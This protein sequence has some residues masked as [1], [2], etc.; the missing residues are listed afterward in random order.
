L[1]SLVPPHES[2]KATRLSGRFYRP[3]LDVLRF[4]AFLMVYLTHTIQVVP[5]SPHWVIALSNA[6]GFGVPIFFALSAYLITEL[7]MIEKRRSGTVDLPAFYVRRC[8]RIWPLYFLLLFLG[9]ALSRASSEEI[10]V[11]ALLAY[12]FFVGNWYTSFHDFL[13]HAIGPLW[14]IPVEEQFYLFWPIFVR[15]LGRRGLGVLCCAGWTLSQATLIALCR[16]NNI[17]EPKIWANS[18]VHLQYFALGAGVS[19]YL[20]GAIPR[21]NGGLRTVM[22]G[23]AFVILFVSDFALN[24]NTPGPQA[25]FAQGYLELLFGGL[26]TA[27]LLIGFLGCGGL[28]KRI[29]LRYLGKISY[30]LYLFHIPC[31]TLVRKLAP[32]LLGHASPLFSAVVA[33]P[34]TIGVASVSYR[35]FE[36]PFL[37]MKERF[38]VVQ[39][40][41][42]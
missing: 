4:V 7:L 36:S 35:Y 10:S 41:G 3:E 40:R 13:P 19:L 9:F 27:L 1:D 30:G 8:L 16:W 6:T 29:T 14:S 26:A 39:S 37:R 18:V 28:Q 17:A 38:T 23:A 15:F 2:L 24:Q 12:L 33:L 11:S 20:D 5:G 21:I 32:H 42:I 31:F 25:S 22:I 34:L